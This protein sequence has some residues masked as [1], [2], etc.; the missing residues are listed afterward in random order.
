[1]IV[2]DSYVE[3]QDYGPSIE[4][5]FFVTVPARLPTEYSLW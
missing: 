5:F 4:Y 2:T 3:L 1:M